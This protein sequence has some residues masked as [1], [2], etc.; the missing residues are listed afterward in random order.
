MPLTA[1]DV[2]EGLSIDESIVPYY[3]RHSCKQFIS[4]KSIPFGCK[5][6][7]LASVTGVLIKLKFI[8]EG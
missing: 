8:E 5:L 6:W 4:A 3:G 7:V 2:H 1:S